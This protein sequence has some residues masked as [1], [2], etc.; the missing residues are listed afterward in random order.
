VRN[1]KLSSAALHVYVDNMPD[2][3]EITC[4]VHASEHGQVDYQ[5]MIS[6]HLQPHGRPITKTWKASGDVG[7]WVQID[8]M[9]GIVKKWL[10]CKYDCR[11]ALHIR[12]A[13]SPND[14]NL[15]VLPQSRVGGEQNVR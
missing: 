14:I 3:G 10:S 5:R 4:T 13:A 15:A 7:E 2:D 8:G 12:C 6:Q 9:N 1:I 11:H